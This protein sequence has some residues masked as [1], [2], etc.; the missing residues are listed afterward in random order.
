MM[1]LSKNLFVNYYGEKMQ[2]VSKEFNLH[3]N[4]NKYIQSIKKRLDITFFT[5]K[6]SLIN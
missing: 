4:K 1:Y 3:F 6:K 5:T 2:N